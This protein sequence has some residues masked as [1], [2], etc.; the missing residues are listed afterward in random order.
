M[1]TN[2]LLG[3]RNGDQQTVAAACAGEK[4]HRGYTT[5]LSDGLGTTVFVCEPLQHSFA[6]LAKR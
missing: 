2:G 5:F 1:K 6:P 3:I 4:V